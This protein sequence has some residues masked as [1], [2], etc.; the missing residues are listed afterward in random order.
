MRNKLDPTP[1]FAGSVG[2]LMTPTTAP[3]PAKHHLG[4]AALLEAAAAPVLTCVR[5]RHL[6]RRVV[7]RE[8]EQRYRGS[9][10]GVLWTLI[11]PLLML[12]VYT[13]VFSQVFHSGWSGEATRAPFALILFA[14]LIVFGILAEPLNRA[15]ALMLENVSYIKKVVFPLDILAWVA[16]ASNLFHAAVSLAI[17]LVIHLL[18]VGV[19]PWT[20]ILL[21]LVLLP[22]C[23][24]TLGATWLLAS[25]GVF[26]RDL[27]QVVP[28]LTTMLMF[29]SPI[30]F[31]RT[32]AGRYEVLM[33]LNP[34][35]G[36]LDLA[37]DVLVF[38]RLPDWRLWSI[39]LLASWL[40][41]TLGHV[42][43]QRLRRGFADV[44]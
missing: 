14:G 27:R 5:H 1:T 29:L 12:A 17:W 38:G 16:L 24:F 25:L 37:R 2:Y 33:T 7:R 13:F 35:A 9:F 18:F 22:L 19:P 21:P 42:A 44:V 4:L 11:T 30:F 43:F 32:A 34:L 40:T 23:L 3:L 39:L 10:L 31:P 26:L 8:I 41:F 6:I 20:A 28:V 36:I 15:P